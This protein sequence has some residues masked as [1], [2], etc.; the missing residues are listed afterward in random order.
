MAAKKVLIVEDDP[1]IRGFVER[2]L[3]SYHY[4]VLTAVDGLAGVEL[5]RK[6]SPAWILLDVMMPK[7]DGFQVSQL[8]KEAKTTK[9]IPILFMTS[10]SK[11]GDVEKA[12]S[13]GAN[14]Y[15]IKPFQA[16]QLIKKVE[17]LLPE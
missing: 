14:D 15:L 10:L 7:M 3:R 4:E 6:E 11:M 12:F 8:L 5:A 9:D 17:K 13:L 1:G 16:A 2:L